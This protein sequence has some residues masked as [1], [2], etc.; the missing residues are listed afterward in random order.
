MGWNNYEGRGQ[1]APPTRILFWG[2]NPGQR[3]QDFVRGDVPAA[4][5]VAVSNILRAGD[6]VASYRGWAECRICGA[7]LGSRDV[8][9]GGF[10]WPEKAEHYIETHGVW[11]PGCQRLL[12]EQGGI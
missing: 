5:R 2:E 4:A 1:A 3:P 11:T 8:G 9:K 12:E 10:V 6:E 7:H